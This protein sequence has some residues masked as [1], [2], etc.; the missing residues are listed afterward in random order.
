M[1]VGERGVWLTQSDTEIGAEVW[2][3][4]DPVFEL[5][6]TKRFSVLAVL[7]GAQSFCAFR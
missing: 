3:S 4:L 6:L 7:Y 5:V 1:D 2:M